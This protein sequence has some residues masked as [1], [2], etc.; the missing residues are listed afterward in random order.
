MN[1][2]LLLIITVLLLL[3]WLRAM[4]REA[5]EWN[6]ARAFMAKIAAE[7]EYPDAEKL[8]GIFK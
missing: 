3:L 1:P 6:E 4:R 5:R 8:R 2:W 7:R